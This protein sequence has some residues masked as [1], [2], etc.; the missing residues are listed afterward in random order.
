MLIYYWYRDDL[1]LESELTCLLTHQ[2]RLKSIF[3]AI[4]WMELIRKRAT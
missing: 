2:E 4:F 1:A 3:F